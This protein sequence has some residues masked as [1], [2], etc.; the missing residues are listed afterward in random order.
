MVELIIGVY[1]GI[2]W[3]LFKK[4]KLIPVTTYTICT[5]ILGGVSILLLLFILLS[6]YH[7]V[8]H[9]GWLYGPV[10]EINPAVKGMVVD[11]PVEGNKP[12]KT[13]DVLFRI[14]PRPFEIEV[15]RLQASLAAKNT[16][17]AQL[18]EQ[19]AAASAGTNAAKAKLV[20]GESEFDRQA[21]E[22]HARAVAQVQQVQA[23]KDLAKTEFDRISALFKDGNAAQVELD[24]QR[25]LLLS[26]EEELSQAGSS[27]RIARE[28]MDSGSSSLEAV[29][30]EIA[31]GEAAE[32]EI[33]L[34]IEADSDG[35]NPEI[36][37]A[38][39]ELEFKRWELEQTEVR[40]PGN[41]F[42]PTVLLRPGQLAVPM[43]MR[44]LMM[45]VMA[46]KPSLSATFDQRAIAGIKPGMEAEVIFRAYPGRSFKV[47]V[48]R[49][50]SAIP[51]GELNATGNLFITT[52]KSA[53]GHVPVIFDYGEDVA[54][55]GLPI[56]A[57][58][59]IAI[60]TDKVHALSIVRKIILRMKSW[61]NYVF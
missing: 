45:F 53:K 38:M 14:D 56:G 27:E 48:R 28:K 9:D 42:V 60:Y 4:L 11:V 33:R 7:P 17:L 21:R 41:G 47:K 30:Q 61:E 52:P 29:R 59:S 36:R 51:E 46:E 18:S 44:P 49:V 24:R 1:G 55:L 23:R 6:V 20:V 32:R 31:Q 37:Q 5:A 35:V 16:K 22:S 25:T 34:Q 8:S 40:A 54:A 57:K 50:L 12:L 19:L 39:A 2:C 3:L 26:L 58:A 15:E 43:P 10:V 13:G